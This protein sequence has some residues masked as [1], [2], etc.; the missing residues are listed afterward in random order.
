MPMPRWMKE[1]WFQVQRSIDDLTVKQ[2][3]TPSITEIA[4]HT[5]LPEDMTEKVLVGQASFHVASFDAPLSNDEGELILSEV[6][7]TEAREFHAIET[8]LDFSNALSKL[9][10]IEKRI[11]HLNFIQG[12][13]QRAIATELG[14]S[15]MTVSRMMK[16]ALEKLRHSLYSPS[17]Y[18]HA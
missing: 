1:K 13:S 2:E 3:R 14:V 18:L 12:E 16:R 17:P 5:N 7:G 10:E 11:L 4:E 8:N 9:S 15:Q 6:I